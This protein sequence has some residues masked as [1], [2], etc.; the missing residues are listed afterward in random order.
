MNV[1][2][3]KNNSDNRKVNKSLTTIKTIQNVFF[4]NEVERGNVTLELAYDADLLQANYCYIDETGYYYFLSEPTLGKQR[5]LFNCSTDLLMTYKNEILNLGCIINRQ[6]TY[7]NS[8]FND[9]EAPILAKRKVN[10]FAFPQGFGTYKL[11]L[12]TNGS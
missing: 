10:T 4:K 5:L 12:A 6:E 9:N 8:Y 1:T 11:I 2:F 7:F 3:Y